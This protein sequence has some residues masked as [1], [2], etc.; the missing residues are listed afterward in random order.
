MEDVQVSPAKEIKAIDRKSVHRICSGQVVLTLA[1]AVKELVENSIDAGAVSVEIKLKDYGLESIEVSDNGSGV[2]ESNFEGLTLKHHTSKLQDFTDL[3]NVETFGFRGEALSSL[4]ALSSLTVTTKHSN[5]SVGTKLEFDHNGKIKT[6]SPHPRQ[7]GTTVLLQ[8]LFSTLPVRH[9]EFQRNVKKE[10]NKMVQVLNYYCIISTGVRI[11]CTNQP[12]KGSRSTVVSSNGNKSLRENITDVFGPKQMQSLSEFVKYNPSEDVLEEFNLKTTKDITDCFSLE[13]YVSK[14]QH[15]LGRSATDRQFVFINKRPC[16]SSKISKVINEVY[17]QYNRHQYPFVAVNITMRKESVDV[18]VTPDK[19]QIFMENEK[20][21]LATIKMSLVRMYEHT[22][23]AYP[24]SMVT[25]KFSHKY[26][27]PE[28]SGQESKEARMER[29]CIGTK[30]QISALSNLKRKFSSSFSKT[31]SPSGAASP[32]QKDRSPASKQ[33]RLDKFVFK[34]S[35]RKELRDGV[36]EMYSPQQEKSDSEDTVIILEEDIT[37][38]SDLTKG[39]QIAKSFASENGL[40]MGPDGDCPKTDMKIVFHSHSDQSEI[41]EG[42]AATLGLNSEDGISNCNPLCSKEINDMSLTS[43]NESGEQNLKCSVTGT[44]SVSKLQDSANCL[45][46]SIDDSTASSMCSEKTSEDVRECS[47][48]V[49][50]SDFIPSDIV[51][52]IKACGD[53]T[54]CSEDTDLLAGTTGCLEDTQ[55][56]SDSISGNTSNVS[57]RVNDDKLKNLD[58]LCKTN[59]ICS[60][61]TGSSSPTENNQLAVTSLD[62]KESHSRRETYVQFNFT[63]LKEKFQSASRKRTS[64]NEMYRRFRAVISPNENQSAEE[65][66]N[67][68]ISKSMFREMEI[69]GQFN[70]GFIIVKLDNDLFIVDQHATDEKYNFEMLQQ[71]TV[72]QCQKLIQPQNLELTASNETILND[73]LE[74]FKKNGFD[75]IIDE[76]AP[77]MQRV[78]LTSIPVSRNWT[79]GKEDIEELIFMLSDSPNVMCR[80]SRVRQMFASRA[81]RKSIMIGTA[82]KKS[83]MKRLV[84]HMGEIEQPWNCPHG[85]P[86]MR[87]LINL[88]MVPK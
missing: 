69:L 53:V 31:E 84:C 4:C 86:T 72:I 57:K 88:D 14:C 28:K 83:E 20:I 75:F 13:G 38:S 7:S 51:K 35:P 70:L 67:R 42:T 44:S 16:D 39:G 29:Q 63:Q 30:N 74:V 45:K 33:R 11:T 12:K 54:M 24:L 60:D 49:L 46:S 18:N 19:R 2:E 10:F 55:L 48:D 82:L 56:C 15:G 34:T 23:S 32:S 78:R 47:D 17:H 66:L 5:A 3:I 79:F 64:E 36:K 65:E 6:K 87:H 26:P 8:N 9:K 21:L 76:S 50:C 77:P 58:H 25:N 80:P 68:E 85:R 27:S 40:T 59:S 81:C 71:H 73:N 22:V 1:T 41:T 43:Q 62:Q 52:D 37:K 61:L